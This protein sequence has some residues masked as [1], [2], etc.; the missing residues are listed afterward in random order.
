MKYKVL[1]SSRAEADLMEHIAFLANKKMESAEKL[2]E[3][4][5]SLIES[6]CEFPQRYPKYFAFYSYNEYRKAVYSNYLVLYHIEDD[7]VIVARILDGRA[8]NK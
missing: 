2:Y 4:L 3:E 8:Q 1:I 7:S 5:L 6:L